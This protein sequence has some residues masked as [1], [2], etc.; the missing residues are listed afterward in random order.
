VLGDGAPWF[1]HLADEHFSEA[2]HIVDRFHAQQHLSGVAN[3]STPPAATW[4]DMAR[5][6]HDEL[7]AGDLDA[8]LDALRRHAATDDAARECVDYVTTNRARMRYAAFQNQG[9]CTSAGA[10]RPAAR[11]PSACGVSARACSGPSP[12]PARLSPCVAV[13]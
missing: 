11:P 4:R 1:W 12:G 5:A 7:D 8:L 10:S 6:R 3:R 2:V 13:S 9:W